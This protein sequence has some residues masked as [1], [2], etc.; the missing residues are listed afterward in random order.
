MSSTLAY[1]LYN[2]PALVLWVGS[3]V[4]EIKAGEAPWDLLCSNKP[5]ILFKFSLIWL[6]EAAEK[7]IIGGQKT[8]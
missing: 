8:Y 1:N 4:P 3:P 7:R 5:V 6:T 2:L